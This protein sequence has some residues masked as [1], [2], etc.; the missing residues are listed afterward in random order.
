MRMVRAELLKMR[1]S[2]MGK[3]IW[4]VPAAAVVL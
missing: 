4:L 3:L 1:H 2:T